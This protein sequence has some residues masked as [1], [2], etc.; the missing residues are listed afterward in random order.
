MPME[1]PGLRSSCT[2]GGSR[3]PPDPSDQREGG[4]PH[5]AAETS[6]PWTE[7]GAV[8]KLFLDCGD[9]IT[10]L[11]ELMEG[12]GPEWRDSMEPTGHTCNKAKQG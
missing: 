11:S 2:G 8:L 12:I 10:S 5:H 7:G 1:R 4:S 6:S 9:T 3:N